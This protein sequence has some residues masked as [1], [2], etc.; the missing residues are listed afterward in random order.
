M[1]LGLV[2]LH[3]KGPLQGKLFTL[4]N[5]A[6]SLRWALTGSRSSHQQE[7]GAIVVSHSWQHLKLPLKFFLVLAIQKYS[8]MSL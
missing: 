2:D 8:D 7:V 6:S 1:G 3:I 4:K 5:L